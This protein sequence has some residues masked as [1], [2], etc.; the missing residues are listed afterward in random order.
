[1]IQLALLSFIGFAGGFAV[2]GGLVAFLTVLDVIPRLI[3]LTKTAKQLK[4]YEFA[5]VLGSVFC[6]W[7]SLGDPRFSLS[8]IFL[9]IVGLASGTFIG[10]LAAGLTEILNV[11]PITMK[12][13]HI[14]GKIK[15]LIWAIVFGKIFASLF[16]WLYFVH[17]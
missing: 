5:V 7:T 16:Q 3:Q 15:W 2:G 14:D 17:Y 12:R 9:I 1:M 11:F 8:A 13:L 6:I 10:L 4:H